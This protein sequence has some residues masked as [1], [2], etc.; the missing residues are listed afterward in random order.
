MSREN[1]ER[2]RRKYALR[3]ST[4]YDRFALYDVK[5]NRVI[6]KRIITR[7]GDEGMVSVSRADPTLA[8]SCNKYA[9]YPPYESS[10]NIFSYRNVSAITKYYYYNPNKL[11]FCSSVLC[12][13]SFFT[14]GPL[15]SI[16]ISP[17]YHDTNVVHL[18]KDSG[19]LVLDV[20]KYI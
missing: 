13:E 19:Y 11:N 6:Q 2:R 14:K 3:I 5:N 20:W 16:S 12:N 17:Q 9:C 7:A 8:Y 10:G 4:P 1:I 15:Y 18:F